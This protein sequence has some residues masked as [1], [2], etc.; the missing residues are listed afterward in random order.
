[1]LTPQADP[2]AFIDIGVNLTNSRFDKDRLQVI[3]QAREAGV[4]AQ[5]ITGT[6]AQES[7]QAFELARKHN[8]LFATA[9]CHPH[10]AQRMTIEDFEIIKS[11]QN[12]PEV[13]AI[14]E[15]GL[16]FNR[17]F[18]PP[19]SQQ[20][21]FRQQLELAC[22]LQQPLFLHERDASETMLAM[23]DEFEGKLPK[24]VIH[25]FTG[26]ESELM[27]YLERDLYIGIT[28]WICDERRGKPLADIVHLIPDD[29]LMIETDAPYLIPRDI[30]PKPKS[31]RN[32]P[33]YLPHIANKIAQCRSQSWEHIATISSQ[34]AKGFFQLSF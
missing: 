20:Q 17:N 23:L 12:Q 16:D 30:K 18:S 5:I 25:C 6:N 13:V 22:V 24:A 14:G 26:S 11:L 3:N 33:Q 28:G 19:D 8:G 21:V 9:G 27:A 34:N 32:L 1:M 2:L 29:K 7:Q 31:S 10:D 4:V 15:C